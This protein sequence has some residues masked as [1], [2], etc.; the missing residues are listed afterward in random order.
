[1]NIK[2]KKGSKSAFDLWEKAI[3]VIYNTRREQ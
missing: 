1:M 3:I 2:E